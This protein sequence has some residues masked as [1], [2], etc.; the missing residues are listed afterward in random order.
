LVKVTKFGLPELKARLEP[1]MTESEVPDKAAGE[2]LVNDQQFG[3]ATTDILSEIYSLGVTLYFLLTGV[4]LSAEAL[5][6][7]PKFSRFAR[8]LR[9]LL[10]RLMHRNPDQRPKD[11]LVV[12]EMIRQSLAK[13]ERRRSLSDRYG[14]PLR[15][16]VP[17]RREA[18]PRLLVR[19]AAVV[20]VLLLLAAI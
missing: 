4:A 3:V 9:V 15:T 13:I 8:P 7:V 18:R 10:G 17:R 2:Q 5:Q 20:G 12:T 6:H 1:Q 19:T 14:I 11:L 16:S